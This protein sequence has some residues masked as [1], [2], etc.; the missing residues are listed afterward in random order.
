MSYKRPTVRPVATPPP[1]TS[2]AAAI[3]REDRLKLISEL[4]ETISTL[5]AVVQNMPTGWGS[6]G[7]KLF[8]HIDAMAQSIRDV[9]DQIMEIGG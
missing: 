6:E 1:I 4:R 3:M 7:D 9:S 5:G 2:E 8:G